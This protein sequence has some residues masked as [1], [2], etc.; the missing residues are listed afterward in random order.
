MANK[1]TGK[2]E[3]KNLG[4]INCIMVKNEC[5]GKWKN[6]KI[7]T[8]RSKIICRFYNFYHCIHQYI[9]IHHKPEGMLSDKTV[10]NERVGKLGI[11]I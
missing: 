6:K 7:R 4:Q 1:R 10:P 8:T 2:K 11:N 5:H 9:R 3:E